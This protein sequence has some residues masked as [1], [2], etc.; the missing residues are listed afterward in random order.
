MRNRQRQTDQELFALIASIYFEAHAR[1]GDHR[2]AFVE[3]VRQALLEGYQPHAAW[4]TDAMLRMGRP[5]HAVLLTHPE[6]LMGFQVIVGGVGG[7]VPDLEM[8]A[9][10]YTPERGRGWRLIEGEARD[11]Y[12]RWARQEPE[13]PQIEL[14]LVVGMEP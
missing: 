6:A 11:L 4:V 2:Q 14:D 7:S 3:T 8:G 10:Q 1:T 13:P 9:E 12:M 5:T